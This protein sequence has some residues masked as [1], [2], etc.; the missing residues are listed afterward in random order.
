MNRRLNQRRRSVLC[1]LILAALNGSAQQGMQAQT[2]PASGQTKS[3]GQ[4]A[5]KEVY[6]FSL[7]E[8]LDY[9]EKNSVKVKNALLDYQIQEQSNRATVSEALPQISG[10]LGF[11]DYFQSPVAVAPGSIDKLFDPTATGPFPKLQSLA[12]SVPYNANA[13]ITLKQILFD[14]QVFVGLKARQTS[15]DYYRKSQEVTEQALRANIYKVYYQLLLSRTQIALIDANIARAQELQHNTSEMFKNGFAEKLDL[16]KATV[17]LSNLQSSKLQTLFMID[18]GYLGLK[19]L[20]GMPIR[21]S[22]ALTDTLTYDMVRDGALDDNYKYSDRR[23]YQLLEINKKLNEFDIQ[24]YKKQ[25][26]PTASLTANYTQTG[27]GLDFSDIYKFSFW[28][29]SS[30]VGLNISVPIFDGYYKQ[31][32]IRK[33]TLMLQQTRNNMEALQISID[34]DVKQAQLKFASSMATLDYEKQNMELASSVYEQT[35]KKFEQGLGSNTEITS[36]QTDLIQA[37]N[38]YFNALYNAVA[39]KVDYQNATGKL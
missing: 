39:A 35:R 32:N 5:V 38:N 6:S 8:A 15:L 31:A 17:Q 1:L 29:P 2:A 7:K 23:D 16:D 33:S 37:Q 19:M 18:D 36:A 20:L 3:S 22:L 28:Y 13:G 14:G 27:Y 9:A 34:N 26:I 30:Y 21:D 10:S 12:F 4:P 24:R 25:Y 11:T